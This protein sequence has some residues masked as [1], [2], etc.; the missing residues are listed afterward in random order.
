MKWDSVICS[1][2]D[3]Q[4]FTSKWDPTLIR[5]LCVRDAGLNE[6]HVGSFI[7]LKSL[8]ISHNN[9]TTLV[10]AGLERLTKLRFF[11]F[12]YNKIADVECL[13][14]LR[15]IPNLL[16]VNS[17]GN[18][19]PGDYKPRIVYITIN[20]PGLNRNPGLIKLDGQPVTLD[21]KVYA[22]KQ[23][24]ADVNEIK[25]LRYLFCKKIYLFLDG[26]IA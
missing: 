16:E 18:L 20:H 10:G 22:F 23:I 19:F 13:N 12:S 9:I 17:E 4:R 24:G 25:L 8:D 2:L 21:Q 5:V 26:N 11:D 6:F 7:N 15:W 3:N 14:V 1:I